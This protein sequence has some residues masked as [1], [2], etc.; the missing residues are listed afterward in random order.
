MK[1]GR[2]LPELV[3]NVSENNQ[4]VEWTRRHKTSQALALRARIILACAHKESNTEVARRLRVTIQTVGKWRCRFVQ[5]RLDGLLDEPRPGTPR[6]LGDARVER[7][8]AT[9][10][11]ELPRDATHWSTRSLARKLKLSQSTVS[12]VWRAFGLQPHRTETFKL[13]T[14]P[15]FI[16][17]V[18]DIVGLYLN[19]PAKALVL[20]VDEKSQIQAL[21]RTQPILP[22]APGLPQRRTHDYMRHGTTT[23]FAALN[24]ATGKVIGELHRRHR[25]K[26]F[27]QFLRTI[28]AN[29]PQ[30]LEV[31]LVMDNYG[32]HKTPSVRGWFARHPRFHAH[33]TPTSAS[34][35]NMV[36][37]WFGLLSE[38]QIK[39]GTHRSTIELEQAIRKYLA[40][41]NEKPQP[42]VWTKTAD[43]ILA[44]LAR[45]CKRI[46]DSGH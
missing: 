28:D 38:K 3:L 9:T 23:L 44:S 4:L 36:E 21:D 31:H 7:L 8:I 26:E 16:D 19:P 46:S 30:T 37:R 18:R 17:K 40:I 12:R 13:S 25:A 24:M 32:T 34:W 1:R 27:L 43:D 15:L 42:F 41:H 45:F 10:L 2:P 11:N 33:F 5:R 20:C 22:L 35:L 29:V 39:R 6:T 14:D